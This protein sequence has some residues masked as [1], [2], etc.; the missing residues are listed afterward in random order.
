MKDKL[1]LSGVTSDDLDE[2]VHHAASRIASD[3]NNGGLPAQVRFLLE[4]GFSEDD[5]WVEIVRAKLRVGMVVH[6]LPPKHPDSTHDRAYTGRAESISGSRVIVEAVDG[7][8]CPIAFDEI[9]RF[10]PAR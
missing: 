2:L 5:I 10:S 8:R 3:A 9:E 6:V 4:Q 1:E 7:R